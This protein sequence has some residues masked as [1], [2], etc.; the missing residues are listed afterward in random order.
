VLKKCSSQEPL[1]QIQPNLIGNNVWELGIQI[2]SN[3]G[4]APFGVQ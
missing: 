2:C 1:G 3:K 4:V